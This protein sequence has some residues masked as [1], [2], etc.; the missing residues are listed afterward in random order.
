MAPCSL[1]HDDV[2]GFVVDNDADADFRA[3]LFLRGHGGCGV[4][5]LNIFYF[6]AK[7]NGRRGREDD[8]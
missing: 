7:D 4:V 3:L 8:A 6:L 2:S 5:L 1:A